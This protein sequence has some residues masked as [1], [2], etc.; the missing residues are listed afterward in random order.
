MIN[1]IFNEKAVITSNKLIA[2]NTYEATMDAPQVSQSVLPGQFINILPNESWDK[3]MRRPMSVA[4]CNENKI[5]IIY[6]AVGDGTK[7]MSE[8]KK[9]DKVDIIGPLGNFWDNFDKKT[10]VI[11]GGG[12]GVA[13]ILFLHNHLLFHLD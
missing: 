11:I 9:G 6:K 5:S 10:P 3:V 1:S 7:I 8:W 2:F 4:S 12:V 13:P